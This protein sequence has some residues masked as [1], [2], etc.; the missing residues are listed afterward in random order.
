MPGDAEREE[1]TGNLPHSFC[2]KARTKGGVINPPRDGLIF[3][4]SV[5]RCCPGFL[6]IKLKLV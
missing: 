4:S 6:E 2:Y 5:N 3:R 1:L